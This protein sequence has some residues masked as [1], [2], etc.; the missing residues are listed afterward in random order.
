MTKPSTEREL[1]LGICRINTAEM[2]HVRPD[3]TYTVGLCM[4]EGGTHQAPTQ[5]KATK[6]KSRAA[7]S[8]HT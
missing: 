5:S 4:S 3:V 6:K 8:K 2:V 1:R 7:L